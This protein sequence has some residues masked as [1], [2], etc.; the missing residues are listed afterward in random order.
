MSNLWRCERCGNQTNNRKT[1]SKGLST[2][3]VCGRCYDELN[4]LKRQE[5][6]AKKAENE[7]KAEESAEKRARKDEIAQEQG[8]SSHSAKVWHHVGIVLKWIFFFLWGGPYL[9][10][11]GI[12]EKSKLWI[13][14][15]VEFTVF[16]I[17]FFVTVTVFPQ[18]HYLYWINYII[19][20]LMLI[21]LV[22]LIY[23]IKAN[24]NVILDEEYESSDNDDEVEF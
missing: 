10:I 7:R 9:L 12:K 14:I 20:T 17:V 22:Q 11:K 5:K 2:L 23:Y 8:Y 18:G 16:M 4:S 24:K 6:E 21:N 19:A 13:I 3:Y 15:G 1:F